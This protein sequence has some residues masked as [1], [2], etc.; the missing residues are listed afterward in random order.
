LRNY[1]TGSD[2]SHTIAAPEAVL[3]TILGGGYDWMT[4]TSMSAP[5]VAGVAA[6]YIATHPGASPAA[7]RAALMAAGE[8]VN[9]NFHGE[10]GQRGS[11]HTDPSG[12]HPE[13][14]VRADGL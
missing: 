11:S 4:G 10:C 12:L 1:A 14:V 3:S 7:V 8:P 6:L 9:V 5:H 2:L 13:P